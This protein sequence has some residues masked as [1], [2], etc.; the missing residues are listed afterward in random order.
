[1][2]VIKV[3]GK[4]FMKDGK[5]RL[6]P[7]ES[8]SDYDKLKDQTVEAMVDKALT[9]QQSIKDFKL[10]GFADVLAFMEIAFEKYEAQPGG[11]KGNVTISNYND[12]KKVQIAVG[13]TISFDERL[14]VAKSL[15][16]EC[17]NNWTED[18]KPELKTIVT[19]AF[20]V[21]KEGNASPARILPLLRFEFE[22][23]TWQRGLKALKDSLSVQ[24]SK[25]Y[26]RFYQRTG[27]EDKW[28]SISL[29]IAKL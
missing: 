7:M 10:S 24:Y 18:A 6:V 9:M 11:E 26:I 2:S 29:D 8:V 16:D 25:K 28:E 23:E 19:Q 22:D 17:M 1:M 14:Q 4:E 27:T 3:D 12:T 13:R 15:F 21:D 20:E 5:G